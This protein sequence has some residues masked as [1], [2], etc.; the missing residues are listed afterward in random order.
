LRSGAATGAAPTARA[1]IGYMR[2][3]WRLCTTSSPG[4]AK[5]RAS[6]PISSS[7]PAPHTMA[8]ASR[9]WCAASAARSALAAP[10]G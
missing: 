4:P 3:P 8:A 6:S 1:T 7:E 5:P 10:S 9:P 2:K